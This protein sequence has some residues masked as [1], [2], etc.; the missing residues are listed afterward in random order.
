MADVNNSVFGSV[1]TIAIST[2]LVTPAWK[3]IVCSTG[4]IGV[5]GTTEGGSTVTTRCGTARSAGRAGYTIPFE[6]L[7]NKTVSSTTEVSANDI[8]ALFQNGTQIRVRIQDEGTP[9]NYYRE[10][11]GLITEFADGGEA[12]GFV[13]FSGSIA[14]SGNL[15]LI[16]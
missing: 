16:A 3:N 8:A 4:R 15:D 1:L 7:H 5:D 12:D 6:G 9:A 14:I 10:G 11:T 13:T 2:N